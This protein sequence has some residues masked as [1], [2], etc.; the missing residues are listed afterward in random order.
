MKHHIYVHR[1]STTLYLTYQLIYCTGQI[2]ITS[3]Y[4]A[5]EVESEEIEYKNETSHSILLGFLLHYVPL[6][7]YYIVKDTFR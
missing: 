3:N 2:Q 1:I 6:I 7:N 5:I 4:S